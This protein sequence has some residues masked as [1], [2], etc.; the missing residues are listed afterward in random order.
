[1]RQFIFIMQYCI[2][3]ADGAAYSVDPDKTAP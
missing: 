3:D 2:I 1:M